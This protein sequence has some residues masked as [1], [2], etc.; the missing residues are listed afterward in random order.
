M[1]RIIFLRVTALMVLVTVSL[2]SVYSYYTI[3]RHREMTINMWN[4]R[5]RILAEAVRHNI[6]WDDRV[7]V[8]QLL[9]SELR[10]SDLLLYCF[11]LREGRPYAFTFGQGVPQALLQQKPPG[12]T[13]QILW[14]FQDQNGSVVY[15]IATA[16][17]N[18]GTTLRIGL[19]RS[20]IDDKMHHLI[21][22]IALISL[23]ALAVGIYLARIVAIRTTRDVDSLV[24][25]I[26]TYG[27]LNDDSLLL[28]TTTSEVTELVKTFKS[29]SERRKEAENELSCLNAQLEQRVNERTAQLKA[30]NKEL[31][32]FSYSV[33]HDLRAP[34]RAVEGFSH[35]LIEDCSDKLDDSGK[36]YLRRIQNAC[37][38]MGKLI[39]AL[40]KLSRITRS[41]LKPSHVMIGAMAK[42]IAGELQRSDPDRDVE[43][44]INTELTAVADSTMI[45]SVME[46][47]L[48][49]A[50][51]F[52]RHTEKAVIEFDADKGN[53]HQVYFV[54]DNGAGFSMEYKNKL[55]GA[56]QRLHRND[57]FEG[58]GIGLATVQRV[59]MLHGGRVWAEG[60]EGNGAAFYFTLEG[61]AE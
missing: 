7:A 13:E 54:K 21:A 57:E 10:G 48:G 17:D 22:S 56:F 50:W 3:R 20:A 38:R 39:D 35:V 58:T 41:E 14:E 34:L 18:A 36:D 51:K 24:C 12:V 53:A 9:M 45:R 27:E 59:I 25:A 2:G 1:R 43:L 60:E 40:L 31:D 42:E 26:R 61:K 52:T 47:L 15:D 32:A 49:N 37:V 28:E 23:A 4:S 29:L 19:K 16:V 55:F 11:V 33:A 6:L 5:S 30:S 44:R 46:N 8:R